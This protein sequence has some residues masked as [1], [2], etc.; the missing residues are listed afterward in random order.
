MATDVALQ[1]T[2]KV[3]GGYIAAGVGL[4][5]RGY[6]PITIAGIPSGGIVK[7]AYL[8]WDVLANSPGPAMAQGAIDGK[9]I[10]GQEVGTGGNPCW[11]AG[12]NFAY[13]AD[14]TSTVTG[15]GTYQLSGFAS[16]ATDASDPWISGSPVP[17]AEGASLVVI[18][19][20][21]S[22]SPTTVQIYAGSNEVDS[23]SLSAALSGFTTATPPKASTTF[24][25]ADGQNAG[26]DTALFN[27]HS[28]GSGFVGQD[29]VAGVP[30]SQGNL[31][32][33]KTFDVSGLLA[34]GDKQATAGITTSN[35][36]LVW[37]GQ[38]LSIPSGK[39][40]VALGDS[41]SAGYGLGTDDNASAYP[42]LLGTGSGWAAQHGYVTD[43]LSIS[44]AKSSD[45]LTKEI[46][47]M[48]TGTKLVTLTVGADDIDFGGCAKAFFI[49]GPNPCFGSTFRTNLT[50][51]ATN[52]RKIYATLA[53][54]Q[55]YQTDYYNPLPPGPTGR[56]T[57]C[58]I[59][60]A[61]ADYQLYQNGG[62]S[63]VV[64][65]RGASAAIAKEE[66]SSAY[67]FAN[68]I[69]SQLDSTIAS[70]AK[71]FSNVHIVPVSF[72]GHD[73]CA[74]AQ[75]WAFGPSAHLHT[76]IGVNFDLDMP[77]ACPNPPATDP[78]IPPQ[79]GTKFGVTWS[80][81]AANNCLPHPTFAGQ[82]ALADAVAARLTG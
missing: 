20:S 19:E 50:T 12:A 74:G 34:G 44:G 4:R 15:N 1:W 49:G 11:S 59:F 30:L 54:A 25:V 55:I 78:K 23:G 64:F 81:V 8:L 27:G 40:Y 39:P 77:Y 61:Y 48:P 6:G 26:P 76:N 24:I 46:P 66:Q 28:L 52:L 18:Y 36:C 22:G 67:S 63:T 42:A 38:V 41:V 45:V 73:L 10:T 33:T 56:Q 82:Q 47:K 31:W 75:A 2:V 51:L 37:V 69:V 13:R 7:A 16:G 29:P 58:G 43:N 35:D 71:G 80:F 17:D 5:N 62:L 3:T 79:S 9:A 21:A 14:V 57:A 60:N 68:F 65:G 32:D 70:A 53:G 72:Q